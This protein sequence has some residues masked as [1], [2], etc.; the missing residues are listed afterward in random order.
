MKLGLPLVK[1]ALTVTTQLH[2]KNNADL[3]AYFEEV[4]GDFAHVKMRVYHAL[5][6]G[7]LENT[8]LSNFTTSIQEQYSISF[9]TTNAI[10]KSVQGVIDACLA[11]RQL[12]INRL[13]IKI[14]QT[15]DYIDKAKIYLDERKAKFFCL[16]AK[17]QM[18]YQRYKLGIAMK[19]QKLNGLK[20]KL[21]K[22]QAMSLPNI[23]FGSKKLARRMART[24]EV[25][26]KQA[27]L[28]QRDHD[29]YFVGKADDT[30]RNNMLQLHHNK[31]NNQFTIKLRKDFAYKQAKGDERF[32]YGQC[33]FNHHKDRIVHAL[34]GKDIPLTYRIYRKQGRYYLSCTFTVAN[35]KNELVSNCSQGTIGVDFN[36]DHLAV[37]TANN[38]GD[39]T[40]VE[41]LPFTIKGGN[42]TT[43]QL[44]KLVAKL[45]CYAKAEQKAICI[46]SL[47]FG[48]LKNQDNGKSHNQML[49]SLPYSHFQTAISSACAR[50]KVKLI[51]VNPAW[52]SYIGKV[53]YGDSKKLNVHDAAAWVIAR[54]GLKINDKVTPQER[55]DY[56]DWQKQQKFYAS[57]QSSLA[58]SNQ[59]LDDVPLLM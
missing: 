26:D 23:C 40:K 5:K 43:D 15:Q 33:Y 19:R 4:V 35:D 56:L 16:T 55:Q 27:F 13:Q 42:K 46:E 21:A 36:S 8:N 41:K 24:G 52:T 34:N 48:K 25:Q 54:R 59:Q 44:N 22:L 51:K 7:V 53:K 49:H 45:V 3:I 37:V 57:Y 31:H 18:T 9:R 14:Q 20:M 6:N 32:V 30:C 28:D 2:E 1:T 17:E 10:I 11:L 50:H 29:L 47:N 58:K 12:N 38:N 39:M